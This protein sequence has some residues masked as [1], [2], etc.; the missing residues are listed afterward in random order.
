MDFDVDKFSQANF[1]PLQM[2]EMHHNLDVGI[3]NDVKS[4]MIHSDL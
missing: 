1:M 3:I 2:N 4:L